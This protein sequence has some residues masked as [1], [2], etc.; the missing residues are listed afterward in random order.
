MIEA[1]TAAIRDAF[2]PAALPGQPSAALKFDLVPLALD[3]GLPPAAEVTKLP[4]VDM[5]PAVQPTAPVDAVPPATVEPPAPAPQVLE[6]T[7]PVE[8]PAL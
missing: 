1:G 4:A 6:G 2:F 7:S 3:A 8:E 5:P